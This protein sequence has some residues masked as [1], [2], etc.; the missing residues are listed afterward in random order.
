MT[1]FEIL[2]KLWNRE[3]NQL[4]IKSIQIK[5]RKNKEFI[6]DLTSIKEEY[7]NAILNKYLDQCYFKNAMAYFQWRYAYSP[8]S[9]VRKYLLITLNFDIGR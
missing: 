9:D 8:K 3:V 7:K 2:L 1:K 6:K 5:D 4:Q